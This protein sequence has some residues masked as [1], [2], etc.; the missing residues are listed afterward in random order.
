MERRM[1]WGWMAWALTHTHNPHTHTHTQPPMVPQGAAGLFLL[2]K[3]CHKAH[4]PKHAGA[5]YR[6]ALKVEPTLWGAYEA[7]CRL[8]PRLAGVAAGGCVGW[9]VMVGVLGGGGVVGLLG[10]GGG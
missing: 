2:G 5:Y 8:D 9:L 7:L 6:L 4:R 1:G 10:G 3:L